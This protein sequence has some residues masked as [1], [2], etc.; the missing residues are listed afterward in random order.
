MKPRWIACWVSEK[1]PEIT[2]WEAITVA[3]VARATIGICA[4]LGTIR[5]KGLLTPLGSLISSAP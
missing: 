2:A 5:K 4:Q 3:I 1:T